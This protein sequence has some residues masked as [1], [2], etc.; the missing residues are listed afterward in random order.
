MFTVAVTVE[1][2]CDDILTDAI[3][4]PPPLVSH[5][6]PI[7]PLESASE[8]QGEDNGVSSLGYDTI[9]E[10]GCTKVSIGN[11]LGSLC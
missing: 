9:G 4:V 11:C 10:F 7:E 2:S 1:P 6:R 5:L 3:N 8:W